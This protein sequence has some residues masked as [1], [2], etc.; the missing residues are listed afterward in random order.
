MWSIDISMSSSQTFPSFDKLFILIKKNNQN[1][2]PWSSVITHR[3]PFQQQSCRK[4]LKNRFEPL[5]SDT[6]PKSGR[7]FGCSE[8]AGSPQ[9]LH[10]SPK[11][12]NGPFLSKRSSFC[13]FSSPF[14]ALSNENRTGFIY[15]MLQNKLH[16]IQT[17]VLS[18]RLLA[19][20]FCLLCFVWL[21]LIWL[22]VLLLLGGF[23]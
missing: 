5:W 6:A 11:T 23:Y 1:M 14:A 9:T 8:E 10:S 7:Q 22:V 2:S 17:L 4:R 12:Q 19:W 16:F 13:I 15:Q 18:M 3:A 20:V 21:V